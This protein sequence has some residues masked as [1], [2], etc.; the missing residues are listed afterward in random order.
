MAAARTEGGPGT[1][2]DPAFVLT[3]VMTPAT[4]WSAAG[5]FGPALTPHLA[6]D[7]AALRASISRAVALMTGAGPDDA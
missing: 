5:P 6:D 2:F 7:P 1:G 4:A 3:A